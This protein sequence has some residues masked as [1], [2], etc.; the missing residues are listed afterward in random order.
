[1]CLSLPLNLFADAGGAKAGGFRHV[2]GV[3]QP[4]QPI[5]EVYHQ[6]R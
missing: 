1:M 3:T 5:D 6:N 4:P 2:S